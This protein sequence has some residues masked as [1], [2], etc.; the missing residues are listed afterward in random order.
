MA[1]VR[2]PLSA[3]GVYVQE[4]PSG[5]RTIIGVSTS[6]TVFLGRTERG[7]VSQPTRVS[8]WEEFED[9]FG[10]L[11][12]D[13]PMTYAVQD[14]F[15]NGGAQALILRLFESIQRDDQGA[16][17]KDDKGNVLTEPS[18]YY[19]AFRAPPPAKPGDKPKDKDDHLA[20]KTLVA[21]SSGAWGQHLGY[22]TD[23]DG[24]T[25]NA[26]R[27]FITPG[28]GLTTADF[29][30]LTVFFTQDDGKDATE[31]IPLAS[32]NPKAGARYLGNLL[33][34]TS[35]FVRLAVTDPDAAKKLYV[36]PANP[37]DPTKHTLDGS[38]RPVNAQTYLDGLNVLDTLD[39]YNIVCIPP[40]TFDGNTDIS[41]YASAA[42]KCSRMKATLI[43]DPPNTWTPDVDN[44]V[45]LDDPKGLGVTP[46]DAHAPYCT[47]Y[48]PRIKAADP[49]QGGAEVTRAASGALAGIIAR[50]DATRGVWK[51]PAGYNDGGISGITGLQY[52][53]T[54]TQNGLLNSQGVNA[55][56]S[57]SP[58]GP[59]VWGAR[60]LAGA[61]VLSSDFK[62]L[63]VR[64]LT[65]YIEQTL[66]RQTRW[67]V[68]EPNDEPL[69]SQLR[70]AIGSFMNDLFRQGAFQGSSRD[71]AFFVKCDATT[72]T[73]DDI[74]RGIV[75]VEVGFAPLKPAEFV[76]IYIEQKTAQAA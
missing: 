46:A 76:V 7:P 58:V 18:T 2:P 57:F 67:A 72:T 35:K 73:Q 38:L 75:N 32:N 60:T 65:D 3:P 17:K 64:R 55:L 49:L 9:S 11:L 31:S 26:V 62:Y 52:P 13:S 8:T 54:D 43:L 61:D 50:T 39:L 71:Q 1:L 68:F 63:P 28:S 48:F 33:P 69:W 20:D 74:N 37:P 41:V 66:L 30:N 5:V 36:D 19:V 56:R 42:E 4:V 23:T 51:A 45:H 6:L 70:L 34:L 27:R 47:V 29:F 22:R 59:V 21:A 24:I 15:L 44:T 14:F 40:E 16:P 53:L 10:G 12:A 25:D